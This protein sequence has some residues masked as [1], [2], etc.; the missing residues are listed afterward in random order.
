MWLQSLLDRLDDVVPAVF[1]P[2]HGARADVEDD[3]EARPVD[4]ELMLKAKRVKRDH[5][6]S[7]IKPVTVEFDH[8]IRAARCGDTR[9]GRAWQALEMRSACRPRCCVE[10]TQQLCHHAPRQGTDRV[11]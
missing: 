8:L 4:L 5:L 11:V 9:V 3:K 6:E 10:A 2:S 7:D 1:F